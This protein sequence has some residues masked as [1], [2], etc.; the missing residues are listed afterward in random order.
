MN[1]FCCESKTNIFLDSCLKIMDV[2]FIYCENNIQ[3]EIFKV[4]LAKFII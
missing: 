1:V 4:K 3:S 2:F